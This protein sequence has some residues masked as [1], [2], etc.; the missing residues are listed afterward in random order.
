MGHTHSDVPS[1]VVN[2]VLL[3]QANRWGKH[4]ARVDLYFEKDLRGRWRVA[5]ESAR[6]I[7]TDERVVPDPESVKLV[8]S[9]ESRN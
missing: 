6:T 2:G 3:S 5:A 4:V 7:A 1:L 8:E 9:Y